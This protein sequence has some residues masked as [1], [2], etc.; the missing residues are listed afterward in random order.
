MEQLKHNETGAQSRA[1]VAQAI[2]MASSGD[3]PYVAGLLNGYLDALAEVPTI[4]PVWTGP[5]PSN[6]KFRLTLAVVADLIAEA[7][8]ELIL[9]SYAT[10]PSDD[11]KVA[12]RRATEVGVAVT[13][14]LERPKD[15]PKFAGVPDP[16]PGLNARRLCWPASSR[17]PGSSMHAKMLVVDRRV[18]LVGSANLTGM[19]LESNLECG[20]L[21][22]GGPLPVALA[23]H[24]LTASGLVEA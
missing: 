17:P 22:R 9:V 12:L 19:A 21:V 3:G 20:V 18:A 10:W 13:L 8:Q 23:Q 5:P 4:T 14:L 6:A 11:V 15:N 2:K 24:V 7:R 1:A 16:F